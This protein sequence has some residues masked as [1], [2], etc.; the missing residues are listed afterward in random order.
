MMMM[1]MM[2][3]MVT[4]PIYLWFYSPCGAWPLFQFLKSVH[5]RYDSLNGGSARRKAATYTQNN[6]NSINAH[7]H[8]CLDWD[9]NSRSV[10]ELAK[11]VHA[12]DRAATVI[13]NNP[14]YFPNVHDHERMKMRDI[15]FL[16]FIDV[17]L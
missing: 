15:K 9:S 4:L 11:T 5:S 10:F 8:P 7:R 12:S 1:M 17:L 2:M 6:T 16:L 14:T 3:M 13:G